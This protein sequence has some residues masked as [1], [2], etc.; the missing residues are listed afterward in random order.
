[1]KKLVLLTSLFLLWGSLAYSQ[2]S[3]DT[4][5]LVET[6]CENECVEINNTQFCVDGFYIVETLNG[7][8]TILYILDL[9]VLPRL[10]TYLDEV[11]CDGECLE[12]ITVTN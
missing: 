11:V 1:M 12:G 10:E 4:L 5:L 2:C 6:V 9:T 3:S 8:D 7:C